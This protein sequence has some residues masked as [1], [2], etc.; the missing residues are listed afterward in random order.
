MTTAGVLKRPRRRA[1]RHLPHEAMLA[2][3]LVVIFALVGLESSDFATWTNIVGTLN[4]T[5]VVGIIA[6]GA[7]TVIITG[8]IDISVGSVLAAS[9]IV[10]GTVAQH[11]TAP[12]VAALAGIG[13]GAA[14]GGINAILIV[15]LKI[16]PIVATLATLGIFRG[17][18]SQT[19]QSKLIGNLEPGFLAIAQNKFL[20]MPYPI[21]IMFGV[22]LLVGLTLRFTSYGRKLYA[23]GNNRRAVE[24][25]GVRVNRYIASTY[26]L[27]GTLAGLVGVLFAA[28]NGTVLPTSG[29]GDELL[30]IAAVVVGGVDIF[31]GRG[32]IAGILLAAILLQ[33]ISASMVAIGVD[34]AWQG[35]VVGATT[36]IAVSLFAF[37]SRRR[38]AEHV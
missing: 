25:A 4:D 24:L 31:G 37:S 22:A 9:A 15:G 7:G 35:A 12:V 6:I 13:A 36:L 33:T 3:V 11:H 1:R 16:E 5:T 19:T 8:G 17:L 21:W 30:A 2:I 38:A 34:I 26:V 10:S 32:T 20:G 23:I 29:T 14:L 28:R 27:S 18:L